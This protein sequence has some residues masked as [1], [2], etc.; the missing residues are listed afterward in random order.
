MVVRPSN[1]TTL[2]GIVVVAARTV[3]VFREHQPGF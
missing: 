1:L 2:N 3:G